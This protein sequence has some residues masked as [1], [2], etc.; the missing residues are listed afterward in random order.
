MESTGDNNCENSAGRFNQPW[1]TTRI[2]IIS[3]NGAAVSDQWSAAVARIATQRPNNA[4]AAARL[5]AST[6]LA[7]PPEPPVNVN[8][9]AP[10]TAGRSTSPGGSW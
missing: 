5:A 4:A 8:T 10:Q 2:G 3:R 6:V 9:G 7:A 1:T